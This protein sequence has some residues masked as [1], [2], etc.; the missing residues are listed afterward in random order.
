MLDDLHTLLIKFWKQF[1][2][3]DYYPCGAEAE[4]IRDRKIKLLV[5]NYSLNKSL[6]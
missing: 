3:R 1:K 6:S 5:P 4:E 2:D